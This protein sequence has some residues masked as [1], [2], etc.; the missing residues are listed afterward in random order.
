[1]EVVVVVGVDALAAA[2]VVLGGH[3]PN[4]PTAFPRSTPHAAAPIAVAR[5]LIGCPA[6]C[7]LTPSVFPR[8][9]SEERSLQVLP[10]LRVR[11]VFLLHVCS[12]ADLV[13]PPLLALF[14]GVGRGV[15]LV[16]QRLVAFEDGVV[17]NVVLRFDLVFFEGVVVVVVFVVVVVAMVVL[18]NAVFDIRQRRQVPGRRRATLDLSSTFPFVV[19]N[20]K[21]IF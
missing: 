8:R 16:N 21:L 20:L 3:L 19:S 5:T 13:A 2:A 9:R 14:E 1:M 15:D 18:L 6:V 17:V 4:Q 11:V 10:G 12:A 7:Q